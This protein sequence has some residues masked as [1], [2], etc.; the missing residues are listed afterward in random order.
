MRV[1]RILLLGLIASVLA[2]FPGC[3]FRT[4]K[5]Q[6]RVNNAQML[7]ATLDDLVSRINAEA[8]KVQTLD[9]AVNI[10]TT[11]GGQKKAEVTDYQQISGYVL[12]R[13]PSMIRM[14]GLFPLV[15]NKAFDM[16]SD[17]KEFKLYIP[18]KNKFYVGHNDVVKPGGSPLENLRPQTIYEALLLHEVDPAKDIAVLESDNPIQYDE[19]TKQVTQGSTYVVDVI[20]KDTDGKYYLQRKVIFDRNDLIPDHQ[21]FYDK[22]GSVVTDATYSAFRYFNDIRFPTIIEI[23]RPQE[24]YDITLGITKLTINGPLKDEQFALEQPPGSQLVNVDQQP[25]NATAPASSPPNVPHS[26]TSHR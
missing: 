11:V 23:K 3:L 7:T 9:A 25:V 17:G 13:R 19:K 18:V 21:V 22:Q 2:A 10:D 14:I 15:R 8:A 20:R 12:I 26:P 4:R 6:I 1:S 16:V 5:V 24:D